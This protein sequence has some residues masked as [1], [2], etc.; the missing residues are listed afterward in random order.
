MGARFANVS[1]SEKEASIKH[2]PGTR[3]NARNLNNSLR[4]EN[5][6]ENK[7][8]RRCFQLHFSIHYIFFQFICLNISLYQK[9]CKGRKS[10]QNFFSLN[11]FLVFLI[12]QRYCYCCC[13]CCLSSLLF[14]S[15]SSSKRRNSIYNQD[16]FI[17]IFDYR[18][19]CFMFFLFFSPALLCFSHRVPRWK[20]A[21]CVCCKLLWIKPGRISEVNLILSFSQGEEDG[22]RK[23]SWRLNVFS[24]ISFHSVFC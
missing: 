24:G 17:I 7:K 8:S 21:L 19:L 13:C 6:Y 10:N 11:L 18:L 2:F 4:D 1:R 22:D 9:S 3:R 14:F 23:W 16:V 15:Y 5:L 20:F 12:S